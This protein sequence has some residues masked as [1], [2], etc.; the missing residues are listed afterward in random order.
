[1]IIDFSKRSQEFLPGIIIQILAT[2]STILAGGA[3]RAYLNKE[4][5]SDYDL[6]FFNQ[7]EAI[8]VKQ[9]LLNNKFKIVFE[10]PEGKLTTFKKK[11]LKIQLITERYY[12]SVEDLLNSFDFTITQFALYNDKLYTNK[13][14]LRDT[15]EK[16]IRFNKITYPSA[17]LGRFYKFQNKGYHLDSIAKNDFVQRLLTQQ[18][19]FIDIN[20]VY[21]D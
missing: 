17:T 6:F 19:D 15:R 4:E 5:I 16:K 1:M 21:I 12:E 20:R 8:A 7:H 2:S 3:I 9:C 10:C 13:R 11:R 14:A 18:S